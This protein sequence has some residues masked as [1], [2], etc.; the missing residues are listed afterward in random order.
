[1]SEDSSGNRYPGI[2]VMSSAG[3][4]YPGTGAMCSAGR[5]YP[6]IS[7]M[8]SAGPRYP[9]NK[10]QVSHKTPVSGKSLQVYCEATVSGTLYC[11]FRLY[12]IRMDYKRRGSW[13]LQIKVGGTYK[14]QTGGIQH[15]ACG[16]CQAGRHIAGISFTA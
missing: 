6:G 5:R 3:P 12:K 16:F 4:L 7:V 1:M 8:S 15:I 14:G 13:V 9:G 2:S 11:R 10:R